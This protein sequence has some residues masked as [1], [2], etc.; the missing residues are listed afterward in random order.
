MW[1]FLAIL[2]FLQA[3]TNSEDATKQK[4]ALNP[5]ASMNTSQ[6]I[7]Y[8]GYPSEEYEVLTRDGYYIHLNR[9]PHGREKPENRGARPVVFLQHGL[10]GEGSHWVENLAN[11]SLGF[12]LA[13]SGY[14]VWLANS[15][16]TS[17]SRRHQHL[18]ADQVEF[19][20]FRWAAARYKSLAM[21]SACPQ[22]LG[23]GGCLRAGKSER[24]IPGTASPGGGWRDLSRPAC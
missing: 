4:K 2:V 15:R 9:I 8:R 17:C 5:E 12:I 10:F 20:D 19:W 23:R 13:D 14:D 1:L 16:G 6:I 3:P 21:F 24:P 7:C 11:N 18:S 22:A